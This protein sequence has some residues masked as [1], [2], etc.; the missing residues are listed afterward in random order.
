MLVMTTI[1]TT[2]CMM[3]TVIV[4]T[5]TPRM[6]ARLDRAVGEVVQAMGAVD[7]MWIV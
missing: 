7:S 4:S 1:L 6:V 2:P 3:V 5:R